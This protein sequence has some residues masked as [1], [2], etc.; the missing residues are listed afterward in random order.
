MKK[1][2]R[3]ENRFEAFVYI[4]ACIFTLGGMYALRIAITRGVLMA[5]A[6]KDTDI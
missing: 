3:F 4:F 2:V 5:M 6:R 1:D